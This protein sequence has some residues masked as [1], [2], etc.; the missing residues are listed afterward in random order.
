MNVRNQQIAVEEKITHQKIK[1]KNKEVKRIHFAVLNT[2][3]VC[4]LLSRACSIGYWSY[5][6][7][8]I[9]NQQRTVEE[10]ITHQKNLSKE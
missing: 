10:K 7:M 5:V 3:K 4:N 2:S 6:V 9:R 8:N 1:E